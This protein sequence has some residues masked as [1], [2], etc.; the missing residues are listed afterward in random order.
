MYSFAAKDERRVGVASSICLLMFCYFSLLLIYSYV[1]L[2]S[3]DFH[4]QN[5]FQGPQDGSSLVITYNLG[6]IVTTIKDE[7]RLGAMNK[8]N[9]NN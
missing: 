2:Q 7:S 1:N 5:F 8:Y 6:N 4:I 9:Q 3:N